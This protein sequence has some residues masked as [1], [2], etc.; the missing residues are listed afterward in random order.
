[1]RVKTQRTA[2]PEENLKKA[3]KSP[4]VQP[5][6][7]SHRNVEMNQGGIGIKDVSERNCKG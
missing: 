3:K 6:S 7:V 2:Q 5:G 1:M 4:M